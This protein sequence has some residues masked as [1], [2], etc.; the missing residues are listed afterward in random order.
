MRRHHQRMGGFSL[1][2]LMIGMLLG[3]IVTAAAIGIFTSN[4][5]TQRATESLGRIQENARVAFELMARDV[6]EG[7]GNI[8]S[9]NLPL[10]N[11]LG[12]A[13]AVWWSSGPA[14]QGFDDGQAFPD[15]GFG[16]GAGQRINGTDAIQLVSTSGSGFTVASHNPAPSTAQFTLNT[17][18]HGLVAGDILIAC[19][20]RQVSIFQMSSA[21]VTHTEA[22]GTPGNCTTGLGFTDPIDC[23]TAGQQY[24]FGANAQ[25]ARLRAV[26]WYVANNGRG[27]RSLYQAALRNGTGTPGVTV[28]E[29]AEGV[30]D[31]QF[32]YLPVD[33]AAYV[34]ATAVTDW[35]QVA[36]VRIT[37]TLRGGQGAIN[38]NVGTD[39]ATLQRQFSHVVTLRNRLP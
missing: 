17:A 2:E 29:V 15:A 5:N 11:V 13:G 8:C 6:R 39:G 33:A 3:L 22:G 9:R 28:E 24:Q 32:E 31:L 27:G 18:A 16:A 20:T 7:A 38:E 23:S 10:A 26:R 14:I 36:G 12:N 4:S 1:I 21:A 25:V 19:D 35:A 37:V 34:A 30:T